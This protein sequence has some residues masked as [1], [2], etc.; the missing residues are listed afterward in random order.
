MIRTKERLMS[1][2]NLGDSLRESLDGLRQG[3]ELCVRNTE[4]EEFR[5]WVE[6]PAQPEPA[7]GGS[8]AG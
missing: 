4:T 8:P 5:V 3:E 1:Q 6:S 2:A 7:P